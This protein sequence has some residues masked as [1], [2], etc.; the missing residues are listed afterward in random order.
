MDSKRKVIY[1][2]LIIICVI[3]AAFVLLWGGGKTPSI[4]APVQP[5]GSTTAPQVVKVKPS[6]EGTF[7]PPQVFPV[8]S[9]ID[10]SVLESSAFKTLKPYE[11]V[12]VDP[13]DLGRE[14][15]FNKY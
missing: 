10:T 3:A 15:P 7:P 4:P 13:K 8:S 1:I 14:N 9:T 2:S 11:P 6:V 5:S 12:K